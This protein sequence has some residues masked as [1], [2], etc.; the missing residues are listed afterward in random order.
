MFFHLESKNENIW[1][2]EKLVT[3]VSRNMSLEVEFSF[4]DQSNYLSGNKQER[5]RVYGTPVG[6]LS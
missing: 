6:D 3:S 4:L 5:R 2:C 1:L